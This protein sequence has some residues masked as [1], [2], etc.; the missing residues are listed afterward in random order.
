MMKKA[1][2]P[3]LLLLAATVHAQSPDP[4]AD[5]LLSFVRSHLPQQPIT[6][7][8][9]L[10][11]T[12][13]NGFLK[14]KIPVEMELKWGGVPPRAVYRIGEKGTKDFQTLR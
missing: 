6:L 2:V 8:G 7:T 10:R 11:V 13:P 12:A 3:V 1:L 4:S 5:E 14:N 9:T